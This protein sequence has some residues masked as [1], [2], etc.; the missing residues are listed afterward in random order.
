MLSNGE[1]KIFIW[2][3]FSPETEVAILHGVQ[4]ALILDKEIC[5]IYQATTEGIKFEEAESRI[6]GLTVPLLPSLGSARI[7]TFVTIHPL[8]TILTELAEEFDALLLVAPKTRSKE[9]LPK[10]P[11]SGFPFLFVSAK[12]HP[13][14]SYQKIAVPVGYMKKSKDLALWSSYFARHNGAKVSLI[15]AMETFEEDKRTVLRNLFSIERLF[16]N[17]RFPYEII[18]CHTSS[19]KIQ[20]KALEHT[21]SFQNGLLIISFSYQ[22]S[23]FDRFFGTNDAFVLDHSEELS[24]M[25]INSQRDLYTFCG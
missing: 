17:F 22:S 25:C 7:H 10:L 21:L 3:D 4:V 14:E 20:K 16:K 15:Q 1:Q 11:H 19:W 24:V 6:I 8:D 5:L 23:L 9:L 2:I 18:E 12:K 13:N